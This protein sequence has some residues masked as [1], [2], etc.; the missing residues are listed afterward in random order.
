MPGLRNFL[1]EIINLNVVDSW[2]IRFVMSFESLE[3]S[4]TKTLGG[5]LK[6]GDLHEN[7]E[8]A[9]FRN[10]STHWN[11]GV[12]TVMTTRLRLP[13]IIPTFTLSLEATANVLSVW[14]QILRMS[15]SRLWWLVRFERF[16]EAGF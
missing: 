9:R 12:C 4:F 11:G 10:H 2:T 6:S 15:A 14:Q 8:W 13:W 5:K 7:Q 16:I 1:V 3:L